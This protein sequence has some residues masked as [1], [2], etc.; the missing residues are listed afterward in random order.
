MAL[1]WNWNERLNDLEIDSCFLPHI[2][3]VQPICQLSFPIKFSKLESIEEKNDFFLQI[4]RFFVKESNSVLEILIYHISSNL[5]DG[6]KMEWKQKTKKKTLCQ[7]NLP[8][9]N[10]DLCFQ[11][12]MPIIIIDQCFHFIIDFG[13]AYYNQTHIHVWL[14]FVNYR[15]C[16]CL[17]VH[18][19]LVWM[20]VCWFWLN[21]TSDFIYKQHQHWTN[22]ENQIRILSNGIG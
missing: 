16:V 5:L 18:H 8:N 1:E 3:N 9:L 17:Y 7:T 14:I 6:M 19:L 10:L 13:I 12:T 20:F 2:S 15:L 4:V 11:I 21:I 22:D